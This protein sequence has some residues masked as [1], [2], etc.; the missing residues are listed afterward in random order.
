MVWLNMSILVMCMIKM[1]YQLGIGSFEHT[2]SN[3]WD[4]WAN[5]YSNAS[6]KCAF[7]DRCLPSC[8]IPA[9]IAFVQPTLYHT[10][11]WSK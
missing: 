11:T 9:K 1:V 4:H 8:K 6:R 7:E 3:T 2:Y 10:L 5:W